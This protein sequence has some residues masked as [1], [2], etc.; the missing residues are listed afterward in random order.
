MTIALDS[1]TGYIFEVDLEYPQNFHDTQ[2]DL[3]FCSTRDKLPSK[4]E[5]KLLATL[6]N[7]QRYVIHYRNL[8]QCT[9]HG[10]RVTKIHRVLQF[11]QFP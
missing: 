5:E 11:T 6:Y 7:K 9:R 4:R 8:Q 2:T 10:L 3:P 1:Q